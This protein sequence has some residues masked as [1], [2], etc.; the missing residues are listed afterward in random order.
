MFDT[1]VALV[2]E[3]EGGERLTNHPGDRGGLTRFGISQAANP[4][5]DVARLTR[6]QAEEIYRGRYWQAVRGDELP[7][8]L[9]LAVF[10]AAVLHG[11]D[12]AIAML[13]QALRVHVDGLCGPQTLRA[14][15]PAGLATIERFLGI[16]L[17]EFD[18][19]VSLRPSQRQWL[20]GWRARVLRV[21][22]ECV[23][24]VAG[25]G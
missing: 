13:Q 6:E 3:L 5:V 14:A 22:R 11:P 4:G 25:A 17:E 23:L 20:R 24:L 10:D 19:I 1:A 21:H 8:P 12:A 9:A 15:Q 16:R 2:I 18:E 7:G